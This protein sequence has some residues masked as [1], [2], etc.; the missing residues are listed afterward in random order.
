MGEKFSAEV[1]VDAMKEMENK[2]EQAE[3]KRRQ[4]R[5]ESN[6]KMDQA[7]FAILTTLA[8]LLSEAQPAVTAAVIQYRYGSAKA[9]RAEACSLLVQEKGPAAAEKLLAIATE[10][11]KK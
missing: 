8:G 11:D 4:E 6:M 9:I 3:E 5:H 2:N 10:L 1:L 7:G